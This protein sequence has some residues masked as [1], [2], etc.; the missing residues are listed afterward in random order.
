MK[1]SA[2]LWIDHREAVIV[3]LSGKG[4]ETTRI[5]SLVERQLRRAGEPDK[6]SFPAQEVPHDDSREREYQGDLSRYYDKII[7]HLRTLDEILIFGP[8]E[9]K[10]ELKKRFGKDRSSPRI[11]TLETDDKMTERQIV[12]HVRQ[13][14]QPKV[15]R[16]DGKLVNQI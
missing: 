1:T 8:G 11:L 15:H 6:G 7:S 2:G 4:Q 12:A 9:A 16:A 13:H 10:G 5:K 14:L 3:I